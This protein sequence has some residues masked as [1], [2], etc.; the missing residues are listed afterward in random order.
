MRLLWKGVCAALAVTFLAAF[1]WFA[2]IQDWRMAIWTMG[3]AIL[4]MIIAT[5]VARDS[6]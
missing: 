6:V 2:F 5:V 3:A 4:A 1:G